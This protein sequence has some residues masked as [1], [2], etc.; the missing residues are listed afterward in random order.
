MLLLLWAPSSPS[1]HPATVDSSYSESP[2]ADL[3]LPQTLKLCERSL[4]RAGDTQL[5]FRKVGWR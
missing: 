3:C 1:H 2:F 5:L 4:V